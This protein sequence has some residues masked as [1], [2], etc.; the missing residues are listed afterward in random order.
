MIVAEKRDPTLDRE[1][2]LAWLNLKIQGTRFLGAGLGQVTN[3]TDAVMRELPLDTIRPKEQ[4]VRGC[5][6]PVFVG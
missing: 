6:S 5:A 2:D 3:M 1:L 4:D